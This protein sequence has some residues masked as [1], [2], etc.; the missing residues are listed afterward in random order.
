MYIYVH[1]YICIYV[2]TYRHSHL[3]TLRYY[4][5]SNVTISIYIYVYIYVSKRYYFMS[6]CYYEFSADKGPDKRALQLVAL[7]RKVTYKSRHPMGLHHPLYIYLSAFP[8]PNPPFP[9]LPHL[10]QQ[11]HLFR[12]H[13]SP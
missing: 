12:A 1:M 9:P 6:K 3:Q 5:M 11:C 10:Q 13:G 7:L 8:H 4:V 2:F